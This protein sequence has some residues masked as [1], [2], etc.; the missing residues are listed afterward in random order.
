MMKT[1]GIN[2]GV[3][4]FAPK[5]LKN[6]EIII[7]PDGVTSIGEYSIPSCDSLKSITIYIVPLTHRGF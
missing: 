3:V 4:E 7:V 6:N 5:Q 2:D 1:G